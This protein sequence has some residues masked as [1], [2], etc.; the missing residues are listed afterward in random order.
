MI[1]RQTIEVDKIEKSTPVD[2]EWEQ[3]K[4]VVEATGSDTVE[5]F[6]DT[7]EGETTAAECPSALI[8][9]PD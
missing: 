6:Y 5:K 4:E 7:E 1:H 8:T 3:V 2:F 9:Q